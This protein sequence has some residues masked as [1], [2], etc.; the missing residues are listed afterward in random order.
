MSWL[1]SIVS[2][3]ICIIMAMVVLASFAGR[4]HTA[5]KERGH[6]QCR[7]A[8]VGCHHLHATRCQMADK[9][10]TRTAG[11]QYLHA[12]QWMHG[13]MSI[14]MD[15]HIG[16]KIESL[17]FLRRR[18]A[19]GFEYKEATRPSGMAGD[20]TKILAGNGN[21]HGGFPVGTH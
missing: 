1:G 4:F 13:F 7:N 11:D 12:V 18:M 5:R 16:I 19:I 21:T 10:F 6:C 14:A 15:G 9:A 17:D 20:S 8:L 3:S 2:A